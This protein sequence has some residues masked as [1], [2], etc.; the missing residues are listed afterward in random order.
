[1]SHPRGIVNPN[2]PGFQHLA[3]T[4][5]Y[6]IKTASDTD[7]T[8]DEFEQEA[9][10]AQ[11]N[12]EANNINNNN[13]NDEEDTDYHI[14][15]VNR[16]DSV[17]NIQKVFYDKPVYNIPLGCEDTKPESSN[18]GNTSGTSNQ[19][20]DD[21]SEAQQP[22]SIEF[23]I[24]A[25]E[26]AVKLNHELDVA[27]EYERTNKVISLKGEQT[28]VEQIPALEKLE[29]AIERISVCGNFETASANSAVEPKG[30]PLE[31]LFPESIQKPVVF[32]DA[33]TVQQN[34]M[35]TLIHQPTTQDHNQLKLKTEIIHD[36][37]YKMNITDAFLSSIHESIPCVTQE[38]FQPD[39]DV[40]MKSEL[41]KDSNRNPEEFHQQKQ[42]FEGM[43]KFC[44][45]DKT[46]DDKE[47]DEDSAVPRKKEKVDTNYV[48]KKKRDYSQQMASLITVPRREFGSRNRDGL[49]RRS[50]PAMREKKRNQ[51]EMFGKF[52][53][54]FV[55]KKLTNA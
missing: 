7:C 34:A 52:F 8:D 12:A 31:E 53:A 13:N 14:D 50:L 43:E 44:K 1:M 29:E 15:G 51:S 18:S 19:V 45:E 39:N 54:L 38:L 22:G 11:L 35:A 41:F 3:H 46:K 27:S 16:L 33:V 10:T 36:N 25:E 30:K 23:N 48:I 20:S 24:K 47:K 49:N 55:F 5:D 37:P 2:Y 26:A 6:G 40:V 32:D 4:L 21:D 9:L 17:E 42:E 28:A